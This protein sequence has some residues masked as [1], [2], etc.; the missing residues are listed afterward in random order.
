MSITYN[1]TTNFGAK[2]SL[3][4]GDSNKVV[5]GSEFTTEFTAIKT[6]LALAAPA[7]SP[8]F[9]GTLTFGSISDGAITV[10]AFVDEDDMSSNSATLIPT[11]QSVKAY[12]DSQ[13]T[14]QDLDFQAD[15][16]GALSIDLDS[17]TMTFT[18]GTG[19]DTSGSGNAVTFAIDSTVAT[20]TG[21]QT[22]TNKTLTA[23]TISGN[24]TTNG[25]IDG[26][27]VATD[28][29]KLDGIEA[30]ADVTDTANVTAA[31][32]LMDSEL[33]SIAS[34]KALNQGVATSDSPTFA[35]LTTTANVSFGDNDKA[36][37]GAGSDLQIYHDGSHSYIDDSGTGDLRIRGTNLSLRSKTTNERFLDGVENGAVTIYHNNA[38]KLA[39]T[40]TGV[41]VTGTV[42]ADGLSVTDSSSALLSLMED[43]SSGADIQYIGGTNTFA[44]STGTG[45]SGNQ[46]TRLAI[47]RDTGD[48]SFYEDTGTT[49]K[50]FWDS[51]AESLGIGTSTVNANIHVG[52]TSAAKVWITA[53]GSNP[54]NAGSLRFAELNNGNN[55][56]E[57]LHNGSA[58]TLTLTST[59]GDIA[60][61][62][63]SNQRV[64]IGTNSP[65][66][67]LHVASDGEAKV[68][69]QGDVNNDVGEEAALLEFISDGT[70]VHHV[71]GQE[72]GS[73]NDLSIMAGEGALSTVASSM[74]F[75]TKPTGTTTSSEAMRILSSGKVGIGTSSPTAKV[76]SVSSDATPSFLADG[77]TG[78]FAVPDG[79]A[80]QFA[81][82]NGSSTAT[83]RMR[84]NSSGHLIVPNGVTLGTAVGTYA[85]ANTLDDYEEGTF[86]PELADANSSGNTGTAQ[87][88]EGAY[89]KVGR[90]VTVT[91]RATDINTTGMLASNGLRVRNLPF[92]SGSGIKG[93]AEGSVRLDSFDLADSTVNLSV[94]ILSGAS[95]LLVRQTR[96]NDTD[97]NVTVGMANSG[98][99][100]IFGTITYFTN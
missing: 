88:I 51:S 35:G 100:D 2:D 65:S 55:Y 36:V 85:A 82:W 90:M 29:A 28:G 40:S 5:R 62:D 47:G 78:D 8:T 37:F 11:Q 10:T 14:A 75:K 18:G 74:V 56:F 30:S 24:L 49:A 45:G 83:E 98:S 52:A 6:A 79:Q 1:I 33:T 93:Q 38:T 73:I 99:A 96:D 23:P 26:R 89:T 46:T 86:T 20:L 3:N 80:M 9:T 32:A 63:R 50:F 70:A 53:E 60:T 69:I 34:V 76:H 87:S 44:I 61:F 22:L 67:S 48:I 68:I 57:F 41:N 64:G 19:I 54:T 25:T 66:S 13:L 42:T 84:I 58:N 16:G 77:G 91:F 92:V 81:H 71:I 95:Y 4:T 39:T 7:A 94:N 59:N 97:S 17:E 31:G 43:G 21:S 27:D 72:Q 15:S 12:V